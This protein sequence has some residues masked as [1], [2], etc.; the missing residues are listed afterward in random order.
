MGVSH[1]S[2]TRAN[3]QTTHGDITHADTGLSNL[4]VS[5]TAAQVC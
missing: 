4:L 5:S 3:A 2:S 1:N